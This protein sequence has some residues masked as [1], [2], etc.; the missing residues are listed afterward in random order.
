MREIKDHIVE[1]DLPQNQLKIE[2]VDKPGPGGACH[3]Y[4]IIV[5]YPSGNREHYT[6]N[7]Q[8]GPI[9]EAGINGI[10]QE[11]LLAIVVDRL[12]SFQAG[13]FPSENNALALDHCQLA[14]N[15]LKLRTM[16]RLVREVEGQTKA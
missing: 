3:Q 6:L 11:V 7:F 2:V 13:P 15:L 10:T 16:D 8:D 4:E 14:L 9:N 12:R 1:G 5:P